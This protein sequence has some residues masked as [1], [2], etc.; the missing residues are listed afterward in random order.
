MPYELSSWQKPMVDHLR[1][2]GCVTY[3][4]LPKG[5]HKKLDPKSKK[6]I[7]VDY[8][9]ESKGAY[10]LWD[11]ERRQIIIRWD[12]IFG[13]LSISCKV[14]TNVVSVCLLYSTTWQ[15]EAMSH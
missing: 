14:T 4:H 15:S 7:F 8:S 5:L 6:T 9:L 11:R 2:F 1:V 10:R 12:V 13:E 3:A